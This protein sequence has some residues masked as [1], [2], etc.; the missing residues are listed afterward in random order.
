MV[1]LTEQRDSVSSGKKT[2][3]PVR[4]NVGE[5]KMAWKSKNVKSK[6][7]F[8]NATLSSVGLMDIGYAVP[9]IALELDC[10]ILDI[11]SWGQGS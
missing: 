6:N 2:A 5:E 3:Y 7:F 10:G 8:N 1:S 11:L 4:E 9:Y